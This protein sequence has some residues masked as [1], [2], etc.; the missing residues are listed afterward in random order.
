MPS[1]HGDPAI[2][3]VRRPRP[4]PVF[5]AKYSAVTTNPRSN[6]TSLIR[7]TAGVVWVD[8][9]AAPMPATTTLP[10]TPDHEPDEDRRRRRPDRPGRFVGAIVRRRAPA[11]AGGD[12]GGGSAAAEG[13]W[14]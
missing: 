7:L 4:G 5:D 10:S 8:P 3:E 1:A 6:T 2:A 13:R 12:A 11:A 9:A 14:T